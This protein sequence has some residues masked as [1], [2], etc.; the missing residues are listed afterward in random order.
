[1][2]DIECFIYLNNSLESPLLAIIIFYNNRE[3]YTIRETD[4]KSSY[5][6]PIDFLLDNAFLKMRLIL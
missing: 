1:M 3:I 5:N 2:P 6:I 4:I